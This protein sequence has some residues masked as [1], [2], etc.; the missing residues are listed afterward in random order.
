MDLDELDE[1][2]TLLPDEVALLVGRSGV[3]QLGLAV[4]LKFFTLSGRS[5]SRA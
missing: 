2:F 1:H 4:M 5:P 3:S